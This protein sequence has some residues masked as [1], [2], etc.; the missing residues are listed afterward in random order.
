MTTEKNASDILTDT[1]NRTISNV[2]IAVTSACDLRCIY[3]HWEGEGENG[4]TRDDRASQMTAAEISELIGVFA[5]LGITTIKITG[6]EPLLRPDLLDIIRSIPPH[7]ESSL[8]TNGTHLAKY[9]KDLKEAG[10]SRVNVSLDT[11]NRDTYIKI[12]GKD[13]LKDVLDGINA[14]LAVGLT[15]VKLNMVILKGMNDHEIDDFLAFV[16]SQGD[17]LILQIIELMDLNGW[18]D[19]MDPAVHGNPEMVAGLEEKFAKNSTQVTTRHMHHRRKYLVDGALVE[20]VR[21]MHNPEFCANCNRLRVTSDGLL[22]PCL[23]R[24]GNEVSI[25]GLHGN[26]LKSAI[27]AAVKNRS[28]YFFAE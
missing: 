10:L 16:R 21:P 13:R 17:N 22:K 23:L 9:A 15:P 4:C 20:V 14:A 28:P 24:T 5:E 2:R 3:C 11:M 26:E 1:Y 27:A 6:G 12:T 19:D 8:T 25:R 7:I 18:T